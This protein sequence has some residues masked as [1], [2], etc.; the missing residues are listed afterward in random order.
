MSYIILIFLSRDE[1]KIKII[2]SLKNK[3]P[4]SNCEKKWVT[5]QDNQKAVEQLYD[6]IC[7]IW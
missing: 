3:I 5:S 4:L 7:L 1:I 6:R 2:E